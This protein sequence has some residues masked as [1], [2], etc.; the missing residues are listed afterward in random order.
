MPIY[1]VE[2][3]LKSKNQQSNSV[4]ILLLLSLCVSINRDTKLLACPGK[5][6]AILKMYGIL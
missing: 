4:R 1:L 6:I 5:L 2:G 3:R